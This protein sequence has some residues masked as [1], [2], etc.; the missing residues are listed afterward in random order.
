M[1]GKTRHDNKES[2]RINKIDNFQNH[3]SPLFERTELF[4]PWQSPGTNASF[5]TGI[6]SYK[7]LLRVDSLVYF[8]YLAKRRESW[9]HLTLLLTL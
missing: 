5:H 2:T 8:I 3:T 4:L 1:T 7:F 9:T 6:I